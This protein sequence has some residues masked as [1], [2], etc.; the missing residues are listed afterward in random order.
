[1]RL[2]TEEVEEYLRNFSLQLPPRIDQMFLCCLCF[3]L[4]W[5]WLSG[6]GPE[7]R[8]IEVWQQWCP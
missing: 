8:A 4:G 2:E 7:E 1:M 3:C 6:D 5:W